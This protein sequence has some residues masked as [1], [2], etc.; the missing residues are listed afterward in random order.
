LLVAIMLGLFSHAATAAIFVASAW[1]VHVDLSAAVLF[2]VGN[3]LVIA[4][5]LPLS[6]GGVGVRETAAVLLLGALHVDQGSAL[7]VAVVG[8][9]GG[10]APAV[11]GGIFSAVS[12]ADARTQR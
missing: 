5:L 2:G 9:L 3:A 6:A 1:A 8:Y 7:L 10:Q 4:T 12:G 11:L